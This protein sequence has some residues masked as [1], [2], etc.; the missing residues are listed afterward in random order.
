MAETIIYR[1]QVEGFGAAKADL[2]FLT[3]ETQKLTTAKQRQTTESRAASRA[4]TAEAGSIERLRAE[5][6]LLRQQANQM[7]AVTQA[8]IK[9]REKLIQKINQNTTAIR[10]FDRS[11]SGSKTLVG[12][13]GKGIMDSFKAMG[14][15][16]LSVYAA[17]KAV[18]GTINIISDFTSAQ[19]NLAAIGGFTRE[20]MKGLTDQALTLGKYSN[21]TA[22][23]V[24]NLQLELSKLGFTLSEIS[25]STEPILQLSTALGVDAAEAATVLGVAL[26]AYNLDASKAR[27]VS[28]L[29]AF[30]ANKSALNFADYSTIL[31]TVGPVAKSFNFSLTDTLALVG[32][33]RDAGFDASMAS[34]ALRNILLNLADANGALAQKLGGGV[35]SLDELIPALIKL[36]EEGVDL[37]TTLEL[38][39]KRSVSAFNQFLTAAEGV[40]E[41]KTALAGANG[42][43]QAMVD[44]QLDN[45]A[46]DW[47]KLKTSFNGF[48]LE[49]KNGE[50][51]LRKIVQALNEFVL[52]FSTIGITLKRSKKMTEDDVSEYLDSALASPLNRQAKKIQAEVKRLNEVT[53]DALT[54]EKD[55][56]IEVAS[57]YAGKRKALL[58]WEEYYRRRKEESDLAA[59]AE[60][61]NEIRLEEEKA[62]IAAA[63]ASSAAAKNKAEAWNQKQFDDWNTLMAKVQK[64]WNEVIYNAPAD[65]VIQA[66]QEPLDDEE[67]ETALQ[68]SRDAFAKVQDERR[69]R[70]NK[71]NQEEIDAEEAHQQDI[72]KIYQ[73]AFGAIEQGSNA[74]FD[75]KR[76]RL[77][78]E[79]EAELSKEN[80]TES[81]KADIKKKYA[82]EQQKLD[83]K[84]ALINTALSVGSALATTKPFIPAALIAAAQALV[85]GGIQ[86][87]TIKAQKFAAGGKIRGGVR[88]APDHTGDN[89]LVVARQ[90]EVILNERHQKMLGGAAT[91]KRMGV[92]GFASSGIVGNISQGRG[93]MFN[94]DELA[95]RI[96][97][98]INNQKVI[99]SLQE[100]QTEGKKLKMVQQ[101]SKI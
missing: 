59:Q 27:E 47:D 61:D 41:L 4:I 50:G 78:A 69:E 100:L 14:G 53:L 88:I 54:A 32:K 5:T 23:E 96:V 83:V 81:Q 1:I 74:V 19:S 18:K 62:R 90:G 56:F 49:A 15:S 11:M 2:E 42:E 60:I 6:A 82:K 31:S 28:E 30:A 20:E 101:A 72:V 9:D 79:M 66:V 86:V 37:N 57:D 43:L 7:R 26:R 21:Y 65:M 40:G 3:T 13:Y 52:T 77:Q 87:A 45:L 92:P 17:I 94:V 73:A 67:W 16:L 22:T 33:L 38:T 10:N 36:R 97:A 80:L 29:L 75:S 85:M 44:K 68:A 51:F 93:S 25:S 24:T 34:T 55:K 89:T 95:D 91:F 84:Q 48:V 71:R 35:D 70:I 12:E 46:G 63:A 99:L 8:E 39:D 58:L 64:Q 76:N 98:G